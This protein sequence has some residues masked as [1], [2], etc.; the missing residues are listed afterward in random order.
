V[1]ASLHYTGI[2]LEIDPPDSWFAIRTNVERE[3]YFTTFL[4]RDG[5]RKMATVPMRID[6]ENLFRRTP[7]SAEIY[8]TFRAPEERVSKLEF[9]ATGAGQ[10]PA[11]IFMERVTGEPGVAAPANR[12]PQQ[13]QPTTAN[14]PLAEAQYELLRSVFG[15][16]SRQAAFGDRT[17]EANPFQT[18][19]A[20]R[21]SGATGGAGVSTML[22]ILGRAFSKK[23]QRTILLDA[24]AHGS[25]LPYYFAKSTKVSMRGIQI[26]S[27]LAGGQPVIFLEPHAE[28]PEGWVDTSLA[29]FSSSPHRLLVDGGA[30]CGGQRPTVHLIVLNP[31]LQSMRRVEAIYKSLSGQPVLFVLNKFDGNAPLHKQVLQLL[32]PRI[33]VGKL[34]T[35]RRSDEFSEALAEGCTILD[36]APHSAAAEDVMTVVAAIERLESGILAKGAVA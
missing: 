27:P 31:D 35:V 12:E 22:G 17:N 11:E 23:S 14:R 20:V 30:A 18:Y 15:K 1:K 34:L 25:I 16:E 6:V 32:S 2:I 3:K 8:Q 33:G 10:Q 36:F 13:H 4:I 28:S 19:C 21:V 7:W 29:A 26:A 5:N 24:G 9:R